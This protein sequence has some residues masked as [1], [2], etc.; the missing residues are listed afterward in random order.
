MPEFLTF[1]AVLLAGFGLGV[2]FF[3][4]LWWTVQRGVA[5]DQPAAWFMVSWL[6]RMSVTL[7]GFY[8]VTGGHFERLLL[9]LLG[10]LGARLV[11]TWQTRGAEKTRPRSAREVGHAS[12]PR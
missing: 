1:A 2:I 5:S 4:G 3:G 8:L 10:F 7:V 6:L 11:V 12:Q 9:C